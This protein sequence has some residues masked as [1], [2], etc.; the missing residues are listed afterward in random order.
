M[1][2]KVGDKVIKNPATWVA[3]DF[4]GW[5][6]GIGVG[7]VVEPPFPMDDLG[8]VE[9]RWPAGRCGE[10]CVGLLAAP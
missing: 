4:D 7:E 5:G 2:F 3:N 10:L 6:R 1:S 9:V 8:M